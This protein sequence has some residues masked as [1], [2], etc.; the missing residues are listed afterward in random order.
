MVCSDLGLASLSEQTA[1]TIKAKLATLAEENRKAKA[2]ADHRD[3]FPL[4]TETFS[5]REVHILGYMLRGGGL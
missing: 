2:I 1:E 4:N 5:D 3:Q